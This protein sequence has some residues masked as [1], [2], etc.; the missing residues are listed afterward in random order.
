MNNATLSEK[1]DQIWSIL[2][3]IG[4]SKKTKQEQIDLI[5]PLLI[6]IAEDE[7]HIGR[8]QVLNHFKYEIDSLSNPA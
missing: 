7:R 6:Q 2:N 1:A 8:S 5:K 3:T 4:N